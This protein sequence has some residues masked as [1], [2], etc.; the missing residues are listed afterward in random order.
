MSVE[1]KNVIV[2]KVQKLQQQKAEPIKF[3]ENL[4]PFENDSNNTT[5]RFV[6]DF[7]NIYKN[8]RK[9]SRTFGEFEED[10]NSYP[11]A[12][13]IKEFIEGNRTFLELSKLIATRFRTIITD[14]PMAT[15]GYVFCIYYLDNGKNCFAIVILTNKSGTSIND[16][17]LDLLSSFSLNIEE[18]N[19]AVNINLDKWFAHESSYLSFIRGKKDVSQYF[20]TFIGCKPTENG[21]VTTKL[22]ID[23]VQN[24]IE[25]EY[26]NDKQ[27]K[28]EISTKLY[29]LMNES[30]FSLSIQTITNSI[31]PDIQ[32]QDK[33]NNFLDDH[34]IEIPYDFVP[35]GRTYKR[36]VRLDYKTKNLDLKIDYSAFGDT[37]IFDPT[38]N[39]LIIR[40]TKIKT[41]FEELF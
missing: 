13:Y 11:I 19:M 10:E 35:D 40:D 16:E 33:F 12:K 37:A 24:F 21:S 17:T 29:S 32:I 7:S 31:F 30:P 34:E 39:Y 1:I 6:D 38:T 36:L 18:I 15:G 2:H 9:T 26:P 25:V 41:L 8:R 20:R 22:V 5:Y 4:L 27:K 14:I 28:E 3:R 23:S